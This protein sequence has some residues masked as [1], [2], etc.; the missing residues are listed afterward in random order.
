M[1]AFLLCLSDDDDD[2]V[3]D[4]DDNGDDDDDDDDDDFDDVDT[5]EMMYIVHSV[6]DDR[7][8]FYECKI[9]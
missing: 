1:W 3:I 2:D 6:A 8:C 9:W 7:W 5:V 4:D